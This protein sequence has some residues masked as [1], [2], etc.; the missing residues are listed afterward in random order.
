MEKK[1]AYLFEKLSQFKLGGTNEYDLI[2][3][4]KLLNGDQFKLPKSIEQYHLSKIN[5]SMICKED[6]VQYGSQ[7]NLRNKSDSSISE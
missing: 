6:N 2:A 1:R 7:V 3:A 5:S 4:S